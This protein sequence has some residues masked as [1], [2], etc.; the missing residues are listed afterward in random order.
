VA[1]TWPASTK[2]LTAGS[3][4]CGVIFSIG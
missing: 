3:L 1:L 4:Q 2:A